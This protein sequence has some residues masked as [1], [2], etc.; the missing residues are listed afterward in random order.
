[1]EREHRL[2]LVRAIIGQ[3]ATFH[4]P[5]DLRI[6][7]CASV[8]TAPEWEWL[9]WLPHC[10][11]PTAL[12]AAGPVRL[13]AEDLSALAAILGDDL[14][15]STR[16]SKSGGG[17][18]QPHLFI[19]RDEGGTDPGAVLGDE[20]GLA[21]TTLID[22]SDRPGSIG[23][24]GLALAVERD[25][26]G[27]VLGGGIELIGQ[28]DRLPLAPA[29]ALSRS[30]SALSASRPLATEEE[31]PLAG[32]L[33]LADM[34]GIGDPHTF[35][36]SQSWRPRSRRNRLRVPI[37]IDSHGRPL[38]LDVKESAEDGMG[39]HGLV[40]GATG[41]GKSELLRT[42]VLGLAATHSSEI[43][44]FV[45]V[46][47][48]GGASF[49]GLGQLPHTSAVITNL[50]DDLTLVGRMKDAL[51]GEL[52]RRQ[53][54]L[55]SVNYAS[56]RDYEIAREAGADLNPLPSLM[57]IIDE[58]SE[59]LSSQPDFIDTFVMIGRLGRSL[60]VHLM[61]AS[62]RLE[63]GRLRGLDSHLS[64]RIGLRTFSASESRS[65]LGVADAAEL[66]SIPGS[67][68]LRTDSST[69]IRFKAAYVSGAA[70][71]PRGGSSSAAPTRTIAPRLRVLPFSL[72]PVETEP[73]DEAELTVADVLRAA[74]DAESA[75]PSPLTET[76]L[77]VMA[78]K[79]R[80]R[81]P[82]AHQVWLPP[83]GTSPS[84]E[85]LVG[86]LEPTAD[87]G[88]SATR[89][90]GVGALRVPVGIVDRPYHQ[91]QELMTVDLAGAA[92]NVAI[93]GAPQSGKSTLLRTLMMSLA[94]THT[95][96]EVQFFCLDF[97]GGA[98]STLAGLPH[99][100]GIASRLDP[101]RCSRVVAEV[102]TLLRDRERMFADRGVDSIGTFRRRRR[103]GEQLESAPLGDVFLVVDGWL[104]LREDY[105][106]L[107]DLA[108]TLGQ[109]G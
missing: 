31:Q 43:L 88:L 41:S 77:Q 9:K 92:G 44:N 63:E 8:E 66:P 24:H 85:Q 67:A 32:N 69:L 99:V 1:G 102:A 4:A 37:G 56:A 106:H 3:L 55:A 78:D 74:P 72:A 87:R 16:F 20:S 47:F 15:R 36:V 40:I 58:F 48:K 65:V 83:L 95:P 76:V 61:L 52:M 19:I 26:L 107:Y 57:V 64:Y 10:L 68:F 23:P 84:I 25:R 6:A 73:G 90:E 29:M 42:L 28:P 11:H 97:G 105:E 108:M 12:D 82:A 34:L 89:W 17:L 27:K 38:E 46:D 81:G 96:E 60:G 79:I 109:R 45:L 86:G 30:M 33:G 98:L 94:L 7:V 75:A 5:D 80:G 91:R 54:L 71:P 2:S 93:A 35:E 13:A 14:G 59:L 22:L 104:T 49:T 103:A 70:P 51:E 21:A 62:Q 50:A 18:N 100:S 101:E 39:P 53:E